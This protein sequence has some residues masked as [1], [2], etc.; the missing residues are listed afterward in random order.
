VIFLCGTAHSNDCNIGF[1]SSGW[2]S[3]PEDQQI[4]E[5]QPWEMFCVLNTSHP[6]GQN[7]SWKNL[8]FYI[9]NI[10]VD[11]RDEDGPMVD[12]TI[13]TVEKFNETA[14]RL[15]VNKSQ[16]SSRDFYSVTC[17]QNYKT[18]ICV[19]HVYV[20]YPPL[21]VKDFQCTSYNWERLEC[22][23]LEP[24]NPIE[25]TYALSYQVSLRSSPCPEYRIL[26]KSNEQRKRS[27]I[28]SLGS[29]PLYRNSLRN[30]SFVF[31]MAN[32]LPPTLTVKQ[33][34]AA[35]DIDAHS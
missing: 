28:Y 23:W 34:V 24:H 11:M 5:G 7:G 1:L 3:P 30:F 26:W 8:S 2:I 20:G 4:E 6:D 32:S 15:H 35:I 25:T 29:R 17:K 18:G 33:H 19:R 9:D 27:C 16:V 22:I 14:I 12:E 10:L 13:P 31:D 21:E